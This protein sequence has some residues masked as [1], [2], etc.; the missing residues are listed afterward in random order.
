MGLPSRR[1][2][3]QDGKWQI[4]RWEDK[5]STGDMT[6]KMGSGRYNEMGRRISPQEMGR[7][8]W[9]VAGNQMRRR[10]YHMTWDFQAGDGT[11]K[12][13]SGRS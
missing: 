9:E 5:F 4:T 13:G 11:S 10:V 6:S 8:R 2:D 3:F 1:S 7:P 12:M